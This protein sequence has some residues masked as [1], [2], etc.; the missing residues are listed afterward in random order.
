MYGKVFNQ[1]LKERLI[2]RINKPLGSTHGSTCAAYMNKIGESDRTGAHTNATQQFGEYYAVISLLT[3][4]QA[5]I[6]YIDTDYC[7]A[8]MLQFIYVGLPCLST[9]LACRICTS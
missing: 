8:V 2:I 9:A 7:F 6:V 4:S 3:G 1:C 5:E